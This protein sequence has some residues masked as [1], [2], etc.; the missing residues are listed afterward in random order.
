MPNKHHKNNKGFS[1][2]ELLVSITIL[3]VVMIPM[4]HSFITSARANAKAKK[5]MEATT[6]AQNIMEE[7]KSD[8]LSDYLTKY[9]FTK[10]TVKNASGNPVT[11]INGNTISTY[12]QKFIDVSATPETNTVSSAAVTVNGRKFRA[13]VTLDPQKYTSTTTPAAIRTDYNTMFYNKLSGLSKT[14]NAFYIQQN[15]QEL[16]AARAIDLLAYEDVRD[17]LIR[18]ITI[19]IEHNSGTGI[20][21]VY[22]SVE[23]KDGRLGKTDVIK[24][25]NRQ[26]IYSN[27]DDP[28]KMTLSN[29]FVVFY[30][31][32]NNANKT[33]PKEHIIINNKDNCRTGVYL[34]KQTMRD[35]SAVNKNNYMVDV[36]VNEGTRS[37]T[38]DADG[39]PDVIT[40]VATNL[41]MDDTPTSKEVTFTYTNVN[42]LA[43]PSGYT[44]K[45]ML[46]AKDLTKA[47][48]E[49]KIYDVTIK[50]YDKKD[51]GYAKVLTTME[52]TTI[53]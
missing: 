1:L 17:S 33:A 9:S 42:N 28:A 26:K 36:Q 25:I 3:A 2:L 51:T 8:D 32:Y 48:A 5:V 35:A 34:V 39:K 30:P 44:V 11:D 16:S 49:P 52:G 46:K 24:P 13:E 18:T 40:S 6:V 23:Y 47:D 21:N 7:I 15:D 29:V 41:C 27:S 4:L 53:Q 22:A 50:V 31:M 10:N 12:S 14:S 45:D 38:E 43:I 19:D 37:S 20:T